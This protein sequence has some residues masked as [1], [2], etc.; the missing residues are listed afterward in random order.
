MRV[1]LDAHILIWAFDHPSNRLQASYQSDARRE[2]DQR[3]K[4][5]Y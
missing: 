5:E 3:N 4:N 2:D 1:L